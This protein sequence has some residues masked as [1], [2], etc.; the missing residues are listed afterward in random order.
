MTPRGRYI[1]IVGV[2][3]SGKTSICKTIVTKLS[4]AGYDA[5]YAWFRFAHFASTLVL[6]PARI[7]G[8]SP[9]IEGGRQ[10]HKFSGH[11]LIE[12]LYPR[13]LLIDM[14]IVGYMRVVRHLRRGSW[15]CLDRCPVDT[16]VDLSADFE[17]PDFPNSEIADRFRRVLPAEAGWTFLVEVTP[18]TLRRRRP[19]LKADPS[20][21]A[22]CSLYR[23]IA[24]RLAIPVVNNDGDM[25]DAVKEV[26]RQIGGPQ[27]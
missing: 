14:K 8:L 7:M 3:G 5:H 26:L 23:T 15:I 17:N 1:A 27:P 2:D 24:Q 16:I 11:T 9:F 13:L 20:L 25:I 10:V 22:M 19:E 4:E 6:V 18:D 12:F 21:E